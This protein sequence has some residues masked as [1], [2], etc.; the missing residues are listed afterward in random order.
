VGETA[1]IIFDVTNDIYI[2]GGIKFTDLT[3]LESLGLIRFE[4]FVAFKRYG[5][6]KRATVYY[7]GSPVELTFPLE[8]NNG[9]PMGKALLTRTGQQLAS[10]CDARP[11]EGFFDFV[12][13]AWA[14]ESLVPKPENTQTTG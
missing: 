6:P 8:E 5:F 9:L 14:G 12:Y 3:H 1:P 13:N 4:N 11:V 10:V 2:R 7:F